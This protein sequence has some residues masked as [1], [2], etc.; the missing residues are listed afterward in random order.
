MGFSPSLLLVRREGHRGA[1]FSGALPVLNDHRENEKETQLM[2]LPLPQVLKPPNG[3]QIKANG[4]CKWGKKKKK[5]DRYDT[6][7]TNAIDTIQKGGQDPYSCG[8][9]QLRF[10]GSSRQPRYGMLS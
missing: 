5:D 4:N 9:W 2:R 1:G 7:D 10:D 3:T 8:Q 6:I